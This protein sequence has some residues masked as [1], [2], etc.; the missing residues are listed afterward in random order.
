VSEPS[1]S[2]VTYGFADWKIAVA[3]SARVA[4]AAV[5][6]Q[7]EGSAIHGSP[8]TPGTL[9]AVVTPYVG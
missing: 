9:A 2:A 1:G 4:L 7:G 6:E 8:A 5:V 3:S